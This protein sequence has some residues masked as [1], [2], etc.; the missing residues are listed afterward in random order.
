VLLPVVA[1]TTILLIAVSTELTARALFPASEVGF[2]NCFVSDDLSGNASVKPDSV[3]SERIPESRYSA[4]YRFNHQG[5]R[6]DAN[7]EPK[8]PGSY[9]IV[10][11]G[12]SFAMGLFVPRDMTFAALLP[13]QL[14]QRTDRKVELYNQAYG[15]KYRGGPFPVESSVQRFNQ[16]LSAQPDMIL[17]IITPMDIENSESEAS[18]SAP[19]QKSLSQLN[20][21]KSS[22]SAWGK[23]WNALRQGTLADKLKSRWEDTSTSLMVKHFL[24][25]NQSQG[26]YTESYLKNDTDAQF[27]KT[28]PSANWLHYMRTFQTQA[29]EFEKLANSAGIPFVAVLL[30]N[31][32]Q[33]AMLSMGSWPQG[34]D[35]CKLDDELRRIIVSDDGIYVDILPNFRSVPSAEQYYFP[36][37]GHLD[38]DGHAMVSRMLA[39]EL[40]SGVVPSLRA[41]PRSGSTAEQGQ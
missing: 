24:I 39:K 37:D 16:V 21:L 3:C 34:Y 5:N 41:A 12:S 22:R 33:A 10:M 18:D 11:I 2:D 23:L 6:D 8:Q 14:S 32:A 1:L 28:Q 29:A 17:W 27:L 31:R 40:T 15:G 36:V 26:Q 9:R 25:A 38:A 35:P 4:E 20:E 30:P 19:A 7:L 13:A